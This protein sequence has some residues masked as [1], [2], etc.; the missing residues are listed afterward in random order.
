V[1]HGGLLVAQK[2]Q[3]QRN[4]P[5]FS[6]SCIFAALPA[7]VIS[8]PRPLEADAEQDGDLVNAAREG[9][10]HAQH[11]LY[12]RHFP[13]V[14]ACVARLLGRSADADDVVQDAFVAAF[15]DL[16]QLTHPERFAAWLRGV[17]IHQV[18]RRLRRRRLLQRLGLAHGS[19]DVTLAQTA[20]P[21]AGPFVRT[22]LTQVDHALNQLEPSLRIAWMLR[23]V[24]GCALAEVSEQC[25]TSLAT[26]KRRLKRAEQLL[27]RYINF[28]KQ[29]DQPLREEENQP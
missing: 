18:H 4:L 17:A 9:K 16:H 2:T 10:R 3:E 24:E 29:A 8:F 26:T 28:E 15:A 22:M 12:Q 27:Q 20:D 1:S 19:A 14:Y 11:R 13:Q 25:G 21:R 6:A 7:P 5:W 23:H